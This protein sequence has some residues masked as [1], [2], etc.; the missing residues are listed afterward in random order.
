MKLSL[1][2]LVV[3][4]IVAHVALSQRVVRK[5]QRRPMQVQQ[6]VQQLMQCDGDIEFELI[7]G[8]VYSNADDIIESN[9]GAL[10]MP[11]CLQ[12]CRANPSCLALNFEMDCVYS[13]R[14]LLV[15]T[16]VSNT[17]FYLKQTSIFTKLDL[18][19]EA[20]FALTTL[21]LG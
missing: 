13:S 5:R 11:D 21:V 14:Q 6:A 3:L 20:H 10:Q 19:D 4:G 9:V 8:F 17:L 2:L 12:Q 15:K 1:Q 16:Q 7:T 18:M